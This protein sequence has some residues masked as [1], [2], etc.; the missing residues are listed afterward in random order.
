MLS[1]LTL[2]VRGGLRFLFGD[3]PRV[4]IANDIDFDCRLSIKRTII[5][6]RLNVRLS[7]IGYRL[8]FIGCRLSIIDYGLS[9][10][11]YWQWVIDYRLLMVAYRL[12]Y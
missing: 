10:I 7:I 1:G 5:D 4:E 11:G 9:I 12:L 2:I 8:S 3:A 6:Y